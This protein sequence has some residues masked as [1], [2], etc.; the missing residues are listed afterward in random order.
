MRLRGSNLNGSKSLLG[1]RA[2]A[3]A[4]NQLFHLNRETADRRAVFTSG[5]WEVHSCVW[6][7]THSFL[8]LQVG[9]GTHPFVVLVFLSARGRS[10]S[11]EMLGGLLGWGR[12][13]LKS[14]WAGNWV[15][16]L[17]VE[18]R[19]PCI[20]GLLLTPLR[21][22]ERKHKSIFIQTTPITLLV[23]VRYTHSLD[24]TEPEN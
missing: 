2:Q 12:Y 6:L 1:T 22:C 21:V 23:G 19:H 8:H 14:G 5:Y 24:G 20:P 18:G 13:F 4:K 15:E 7:P 9:E 11:R 3:W 17:R 10:C 16:R